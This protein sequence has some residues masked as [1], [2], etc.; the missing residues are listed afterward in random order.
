MTLKISEAD[1]KLAVSERLQYAE[2]Q[3]KLVHLRLNSGDFIETRGDTRRRIKGAPKGAADFLV[4]Q[5]VAYSLT[6]AGV[7]LNHQPPVIPATRVTF[8]E[9]KKPKGGKQSDDQKV[10][11]AKVRQF[12]ARYFIVTSIEQLE[13][14]LW[15]IQ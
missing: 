9:V 7:P 13:E 8:I 5:A 15:N 2:N 6:Y 1:V 14:V 12:N 11:E 4:L 10:F 3:G